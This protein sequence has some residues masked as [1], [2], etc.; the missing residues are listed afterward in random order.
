M[1]LKADPAWTRQPPPLCILAAYRGNSTCAHHR[2]YF[3]Y[4]LPG[5]CLE[6]WAGFGRGCMLIIFRW[7]TW[8]KLRTVCCV[9]HWWEHVGRN[10]N[11]VPMPAPSGRGH[12]VAHQPSDWGTTRVLLREAMFL[13]F[14]I[15]F[16]WNKY[17]PQQAAWLLPWQQGVSPAAPRARARV[18]KHLRCWTPARCSRG[19]ECCNPPWPWFPCTHA[20]CEE[21]GVC[22]WGCCSQGSLEKPFTGW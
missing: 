11:D 8:C 9:V 7:E 4:Y 3:T 10:R 17:T 5:L 1:L 18:H 15:C 13:F 2:I 19:A 6:C 22:A 21:A 16:W 20:A 14:C 12:G